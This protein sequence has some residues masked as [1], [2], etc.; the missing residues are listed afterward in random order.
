MVLTVIFGFMAVGVVLV[1]LFHPR[2]AN[3]PMLRV[4]SW[5]L[6]AAL[7]VVALTVLVTT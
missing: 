4:G 5:F 7:G 2:A 1:G 3:E 6:A